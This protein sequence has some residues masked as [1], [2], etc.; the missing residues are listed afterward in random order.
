M[1][2]PSSPFPVGAP[3]PPAPSAPFGAVSSP[4]G[5]AAGF[6]AAAAPNV[7]PGSVPLLQAPTPQAP[8]SFDEK[9]PFQSNNKKKL[10]IAVAIGVLVI[11][12]IAIAVLSSSSSAPPPSAP[13]PEPPAAQAQPPAAAP[14]PGEP[15]QAPASEP[16]GEPTAAIAASVDTRPSQP[17]G[18]SAN[19]GFA[20]LFAEGAKHAASDG[21]GGRFD[22]AAAKAALE[23]QLQD[24]AQCR[25]VG[26]PTGMTQVSVT[27]APSGNVST[28]ILT[29]P[30]FA[31]T[32]VGTCIV[33]ALKRAR[34][35]PF[36]GA[37]SSVTQR[38]SIR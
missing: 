33:N 21:G 17:S 12:A 13:T 20:D 18:K 10:W 35:K 8:V 16:A 27:F 14:T 6:G 11:A 30:P 29:E 31:N 19:G 26:G 3:R 37:A 38:I 15:A 9:A 34:V 23:D 4:F 24:A 2:A 7:A 25:E 36:S 28:A 1:A 22:A 32:S 5:A